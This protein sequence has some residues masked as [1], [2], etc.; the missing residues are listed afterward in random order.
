MQDEGYE[1]VTE[2]QIQQYL[3]SNTRI[4]Y[5]NHGSRGAFIDYEDRLGVLKII[6]NKDHQFYEQF[7]QDA[8]QNED[9]QITFELF[10][11]SLIKTVYQLHATHP[12]PMDK[13]IDDINNRLKAYLKQGR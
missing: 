5:V 10:L 6:V 4:K 13:L 8:Y 12:V 11:V 9:M 1:E 7:V 3:D 2:E